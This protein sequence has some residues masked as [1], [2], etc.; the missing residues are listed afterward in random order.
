[1]VLEGVGIRLASAQTLA[2]YAC[3]YMAN[4]D[5][6]VEFTPVILDGGFSRPAPRPPQSRPP[7]HS[8]RG[9]I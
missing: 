2:R 5:D 4:T 7:R 1:M 9:I 3:E 8:A 6:S